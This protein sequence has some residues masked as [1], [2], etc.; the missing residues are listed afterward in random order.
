MSA[1]AALISHAPRRAQPSAELPQAQDVLRPELLAGSSGTP[2]EWARLFHQSFFD[3]AHDAIEAGCLL[4]L[5]DVVIGR[6]GPLLR[7]VQ[8]WAAAYE[9]NDLTRL[10]STD[11]ARQF[12]SVS[13]RHGTICTAEAA[14]GPA[15]ESCPYLDDV[16]LGS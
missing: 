12:A 10:S 6:E 7:E 4:V 2:I 11:V 5:P 13:R 15:F 14:F 1:R 9:P 8:L 3:T 16:D